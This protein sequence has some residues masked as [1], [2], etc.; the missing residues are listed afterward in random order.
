MCPSKFAKQR[1][2]NSLK[3]GKHFSYIT[4]TAVPLST[5]KW[6]LSQPGHGH[7]IEAI[8]LASIKFKAAIICNTDQS[9]CNTMQTQFSV[10]SIFDLI[11]RMAESC[12]SQDLSLIQ[13]Y[14][15]HI[16]SNKSKSIR[17]Q[18]LKIHEKSI[19]SL[20]RKSNLEAIIIQLTD[21]VPFPTY[22]V[23]KWRLTSN[24]WQLHEK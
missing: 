12:D 14:Y 15:I 10:P 7:F 2:F 11:E 21:R 17:A 19:A 13:G 16:D 8:K 5:S 18:E 4:E 1:S 24:G 3:R 6:C 22:T 23:T 9:C 20:R